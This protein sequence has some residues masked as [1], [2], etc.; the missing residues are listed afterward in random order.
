MQYVKIFMS[1]LPSIVS[2][3]R[4]QESRTTPNLQMKFC[5]IYSLVP[6]HTSVALVYTCDM[7]T[8]YFL[9]LPLFSFSS[10]N[11][12]KLEPFFTCCEFCQQNGM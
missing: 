5:N 7:F 1:V 8:L 6:L 11:L 4:I 3:L 2:T 12:K 9:N 10:A